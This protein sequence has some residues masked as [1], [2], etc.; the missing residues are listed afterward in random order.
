MVSRKTFLAPESEKGDTGTTEE[1]VPAG[2]ARTVQAGPFVNTKDID[3]ELRKEGRLTVDR[4]V[5]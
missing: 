4:A 2:T 5:E 3:T 1:D